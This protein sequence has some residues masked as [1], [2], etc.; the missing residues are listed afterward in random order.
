MPDRKQGAVPH[1]PADLGMRAAQGC[2]N[3]HSEH[4]LP[5]LRIPK[6]HHQEEQD[7]QEGK[8]NLYVHSHNI[9]SIMFG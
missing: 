1:V 4:L 3:A 2:Y 8:D 9:L 5:C 6:A 7:Y